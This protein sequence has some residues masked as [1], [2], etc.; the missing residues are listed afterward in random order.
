MGNHGK[1]GHHLV[2]SPTN[3]PGTKVSA[4]VSD[5]C[6]IA[7]FNTLLPEYESMR[8]FFLAFPIVLQTFPAMMIEFYRI[9]LQISHT[10]VFIH[11]VLDFVNVL[12]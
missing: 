1:Y 5:L 12:Q 9:Y 11:V 8:F 10:F 6:L 4:S 3:Q 2:Q 7:S